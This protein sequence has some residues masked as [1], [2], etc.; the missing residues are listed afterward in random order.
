MVVPIIWA[1]AN[2]ELVRL[3]D[4]PGVQRVTELCQN[5]RLWEYPD[6]TTTM[7]EVDEAS[8]SL[9][10]VQRGQ[11]L[12]LVKGKEHR[13]FRSLPLTLAVMMFALPTT[14]VGRNMDL[15][16]ECE[17]IYQVYP[18]L[19][20]AAML[21]SDVNCGEPDSGEFVSCYEGETSEE[22]AARDRRLA[23]RQHQEAGYKAADQACRA[24]EADTRNTALGEALRNALADAR[25]TDTWRPESPG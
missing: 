24:W 5:P 9:F 18:R 21:E 13:M 14:A 10:G 3:R 12:T 20:L 15:K 23:I 2:N 6:S 8:V 25:A 17:R 11:P 1:M 22:K 4:L 7:Q 19:M 16:A